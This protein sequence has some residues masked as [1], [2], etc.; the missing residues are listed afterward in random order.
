MNATLVLAP[1]A[2]GPDEGLNVSHVCVLDADQL[3]VV[4][5]TPEFVMTTGCE[6]VAVLP[7]AAVKLKDVEVVT[8]RIGTFATVTLID[9]DVAVLP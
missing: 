4:P 9:V 8:E 6:E 5:T 1:P 7:C 3:R 2:R